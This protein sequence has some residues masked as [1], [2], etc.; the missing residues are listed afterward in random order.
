MP[1]GSTTAFTE[2]LIGA[3]FFGGGDAVGVLIFKTHLLGLR[4]VV[5]NL[6][7]AVGLPLA[8]FTDPDPTGV[9][10]KAVHITELRAALDQAR[11]A[12]GLPAVVYSQA[13]TPQVSVV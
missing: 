3:T 1:G 8:S 9:V 2:I 13:S 12:I 4:T 11:A 7:T 6:R 10:V 5:N